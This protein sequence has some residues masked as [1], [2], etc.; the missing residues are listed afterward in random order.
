MIQNK[1]LALAMA[2]ALASLLAGCGGDN[3]SEQ[4]AT[5]P[6]AKQTLSAVQALTKG[7]RSAEEARN[8]K[9]DYYT[10]DLSRGFSAITSGREYYLVG[11][12]VPRDPTQVTYT[13]FTWPFDKDGRY[14]SESPETLAILEYFAPFFPK[15]D[16]LK[17]Y[18][19]VY[20]PEYRDGTHFDK[21]DILK[22]SEVQAKLGEVYERGMQR[23]LDISIPVTFKEMG[24]LEY[25]AEKNRFEYRYSSV[26]PTHFGLMADASG[27]QVNR[28]DSNIDFNFADFG[29]T[30]STDN[31]VLEQLD[32]GYHAKLND[33]PIHFTLPE[34]QARDLAKWLSQNH[35]EA[36]KLRYEYL[37]RV[38]HTSITK[39]MQKGE[40]LFAPDALRIAMPDGKPVATVAMPVKVQF[41]QKAARYPS[42]PYLLNWMDGTLTDSN[43]YFVPNAPAA[44]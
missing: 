34:E 42:N 7:A 19:S 31:A 11:N 4:A 43:Q 17:F 1:M 24:D 40:L 28:F 32:P 41:V 23:S 9:V 27:T 14:Q 30:G 44:Q 16:L 10:K 8:L 3:A 37:G 5:T 25:N 39:N 12:F 36:R 29:A 35:N 20:Y 38:L 33:N 13:P 21:Q 15:E 22:Q 18:A 6:E 26:R 2:G